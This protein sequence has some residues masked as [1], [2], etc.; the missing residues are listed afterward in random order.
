NTTTFKGGTQS[1]LG[2]S[3]T[4]FNN[5][6][7]NPVTSLTLSSSSINVDGNLTLLSGQLI[8][9]NYT[10]NLK[11]NFTNN[12]N[13]TDNGTGVRLIGATQQ[14][15]S[16]NGTFSTLELNNSSGARLLSSITLNKDLK[17]TNGILNINQ[18]KLTLGVNSNITGT[19]FSATKM[20]E[21]DG[22]FS[23]VGILKYFPIYDSGPDV[24]FTYPL[25]VSNKYT[26]AVFT[27]SNNDVVGYIRVNAINSYHPGVLDRNKVLQ[28]YWEVENSAVSGVNGKMEFY[29][30][31]ADVRGSEPDY[32]AARTI[33]ATSWSKAGHGPTTDNVDEDINKITF[34]YAGANDLNGEYTAGEDP[35]FPDNIPQFTSQ[36]DGVWNDKTVWVQTGGDPYT[37]TGAPNGFIVTISAA[38]TV[39]L[40]ENSAFTY[41]MQINGTLKAVQPHYGH[42]LGTVSG[43]GTL[44]LDKGTL[45][46]GRYTQ[47]LSCATGGTLEYGGSTDYNI[48]ADLY[49]SV[50][51]IHFTG[52]GT[53][54]LPSKDLTICH[55]LLINGPTLDNSV[56]NRKLTI[57]GTM[58][59]P[60]G[61]FT[62]GTGANAIVEFA[63]SSAQTLGGTTGN[64]TGTNKFNHFTINNS[65]NLSIGANGQVEVGGNLNLTSGRI[66]TTST[67]KLSIVNTAINCVNP[68]GGSASSYV[69]GPLTK[70]VNSGDGFKFPVGK[71][72]TVGNKIT[73][74]SS[75]S[76][77]IDWTVEFFTPNSTFG[78]YAAPLTYVNS[79]EYWTVSAASGSQAIVGLDWDPASDLT[80]LMTESG[81]SDMRVAYDNGGTWTELASSASGDGSNGTVSTQNRHTIPASGTEEFT[82][83]C[84]N[85]IKPRARFSPSGPVCGTSGIPVT[86]IGA[87]I[88]FN[89]ILSYKKDEV[90]QTPVT[91]TSVPYT[92]PTSATGATYVLTG[93]SY[94]NP[95]SPTNGVVDPT[96]VT[97]YTVP[98]TA[99]AGP[100]QS[101]CGGTSATLAANAPTVGTGLWSILAGAGGTVVTP[102]VPTSTFNGTNGTSYTLQWT[103]SNG[104][105]TSSDD[106]G[107]AFPLL[108][109]QP[110]DFIHFDDNVCQGD[111]NVAYSVANNPTLTYTWSYSGSG[112]TMVGSGNEI[113]IDYS[114]TAT[115]GDVSVY[116]T[117][118]CGDSA[119][120]TRAVTVNGRPTASIAVDA[121]FTPICDGD[122]TQMTI[123]LS[124]G[125]SPYSFSITDGTHTENIT[126][127]TSPFSYIPATP[128]IWTGPGTSN[129][130]T[131]SI[132]SVTSANGCSYHGS[133]TADVTVYKVPETG[134]EYHIPNN[135]GF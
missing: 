90:A 4:N 41:R 40:N 123:T 13:Y 67:N 97:T 129:T 1:I 102:T 34:T 108:P 103:I 75:Q 63:G 7:V 84:I 78:S 56:N 20:I 72:S 126:V 127:T 114:G 18:Y 11:G 85:T 96:P 15:I 115:S 81:L 111:L 135:F 130:Y 119:P 132:P 83:A 45:P 92:L 53:R 55:Q 68:A 47:F 74:L 125:T 35:A 22:A 50:P 86:F 104:G 33:G 36:K 16:G 100:D 39:T 117:N 52:T 58:E 42:N 91:I 73:L 19:S 64:F 61:T 23:N 70:K 118:G 77:T 82:I 120:L 112:A 87:S 38:D 8:L 9:G 31:D 71:G 57:Q 5:L 44:Y 3:T 79:K 14:N 131:Y 122:N 29:Y 59:R 80:P 101:I 110:A 109:E 124:G 69:D 62:A 24:T 93:F 2:T 113:S 128:P 65:S 6:V 106:V 25:G 51:K 10:V 21:V 43:S 54:V 88:P 133:N 28:Y 12:A 46:A 37:L 66:I 32:V 94:N 27:Y 89:Y 26:P 121:G 98:T 30:K 95:S 48:N 60:S 17:L 49:S 134:P 99:N 76:G 105:C 107:I 116:T